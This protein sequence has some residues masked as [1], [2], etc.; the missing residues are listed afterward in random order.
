M[1]N[2]LLNDK[3]IE[4]TPEKE[5]C[6]I[7]AAGDTWRSSSACGTS[8]TPPQFLRQLSHGE[9]T[10]SVLAF[11][12]ATFAS[13]LDALEAFRNNGAGEIHPLLLREEELGWIFIGYQDY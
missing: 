6:M 8:R 2:Y 12:P 7:E 11:I 9:T 1:N 3:E 13:N 4:Y 10:N 5:A